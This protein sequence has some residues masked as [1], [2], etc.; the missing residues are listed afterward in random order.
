MRA[1]L[2]DRN[3]GSTNNTGRYFPEKLRIIQFQF[4]ENV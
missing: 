2:N 4:S 3:A 1:T